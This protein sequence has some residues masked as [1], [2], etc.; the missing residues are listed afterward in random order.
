[1]QIELTGCTSAGKTTLM[2]RICRV[3]REQS[4]DVAAGDEFILGLVRLNGI[5]SHIARTL[6]IDF[7]AGIACL[8]TIG[9]Y[10]EFYR[11]SLCLIIRLRTGWFERLNLSRNVLKKIG[12]FETIRQFA[13]PSK[14]VVVDEG[15][16][17]AAHNL[18]VHLNS[19]PTEDDFRTFFRLVPLPEAA[20]Y[21]KEAAPVLILRTHRRKHPRLRSADVTGKRLFIEQAISTFERLESEPKV[22]QILL[23]AEM[24]RRTL[25][26]KAGTEMPPAVELA[27]RIARSALTFPEPKGASRSAEESAISKPTGL[28][29]RIQTL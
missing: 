19:K 9:R 17:H 10:W 7:I 23:I 11:F 29:A 25:S 4:P 8:V 16:L 18:F 6:V 3:S 20:V 22:R 1:V 21:L 24:S 14:I 27:A 2:S 5:R 15:T 12:V 26:Y 28:S 13:P